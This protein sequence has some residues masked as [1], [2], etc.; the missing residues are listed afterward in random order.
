MG[1][2]DFGHKEK[3]TQKKG[4]NKPFIQ[5]EYEPTIATEVIKKRKPKE[6]E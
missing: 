3:K 2:R 1:K 5:S 4:T 6:E